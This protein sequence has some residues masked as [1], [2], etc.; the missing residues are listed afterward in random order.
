[1][2]EQHRSD[3]SGREK[4]DRTRSGMNADTDIA[5]FPDAPSKLASSS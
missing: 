4:L 3:T 1:L 5:F 2:P